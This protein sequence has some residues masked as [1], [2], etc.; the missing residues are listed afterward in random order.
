MLS[1]RGLRVGY[2]TTPVLD[3]VDLDV[4]AGS[5]TALLGRNG[6]GK[7][8]LLNAVVGV[9]RAASG[10]V[11]FEGRDLTRSPA[12]ERIRAGVGYVP[13]GQLA[14][15]HLTVR[16]NLLVV[17]ESYAG[18]GRRALEEVLE[19]FPRL[20]PLLDRE[21]GV[22]SGGQRQQLAMARALVTRPRLLLLDEPTEGIQPSIVL[23][24]ED[25][26]AS[27]YRGGVSVLLVEQY[28]DFAL[29]LADRYAVMEAG[30]IVHHG[31]TA[32]TEAAALHQ[33]LAV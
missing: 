27:L 19:V 32:G 4:P 24:I 6:V 17:A 9:L 12:H 18:P 2:G 14:F 5:V 11:A 10:T 21:A 3:G 26:I 16:E 22:L 23:E 30:A 31:D 13:Q 28:V 8:T 33:L 20:R 29:R 15:P 1:I 25:A 7:T